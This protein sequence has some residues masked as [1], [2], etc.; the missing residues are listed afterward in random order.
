MLCSCGNE[1]KAEV[2]GAATDSVRHD[3]PTMAPENNGEKTA[4]PAP[5]FE[6][7]DQFGK[8]R[9]LSDYKGKVVF[10]NFWATWCPPCRGEMPDIQRLYEKYGDDGEVAILGVAFPGSGGETDAQ[11]VADFLSE[12]GYT[13][14]VAMDNDG[15]LLSSYGISA[16]PTTFM[17][18]ADGNIFGYVSGALSEAMMQ[19]IIDQTASGVM[20]PIDG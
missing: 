16:F 1:E 6:L 5:D 15:T 12:N 11:G 19:Q 2:T 18:D 9:K 3:D 10:L 4:V 14:P 13:Y 8:V 20:E 17:I 7:L